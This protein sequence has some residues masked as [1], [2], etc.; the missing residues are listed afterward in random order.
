MKHLRF[1]TASL[2]VLSACS[3]RMIIQPET[4]G[5]MGSVSIALTADTSN[6][7]KV[8]KAD[9]ELPNVDDFRVAI[10]KTATKMRLY[11]D[12]YANT[13]DKTIPLNAG[14][15][16]LV[17]K[18]GDSLGCGFNKPFYMADPVFS[19]TGPGTQVKAEAKL[20]NV[21][22]AVEYDVNTINT[23]VFSDFYT[24]VKHKTYAAKK[25]KF[26][27]TETRPGYIPGGQLYLEF[28]A[29]VG[30]EWKYFETAP[31]TYSP[32]DFVTFTLTTDNSE[33]NLRVNITVDSSVE[34]KEQNIMVPPYTVA[35]E[36]PS[37][38]ISGFD[39]SGDNHYF[40]EG[41]QPGNGMASFIARGSIVNCWLSIDSDYL[42]SLG[43]PSRVDFANL[44]ETEKSVLESAGFLWDAEMNLSRKLSYIDFSGVIAKIMNGT[45]AAATDVEQARFSLSVVD[46]VGKADAAEFGVVSST[47]RASV[48][49]EDYNIWA[50]K[51]VAPVYSM[52]KGNASLLKLQVSTDNVIW[53]DAEG[54][55]EQAGYVFTHS[56]LAT[57]PSTTYYLR[58]I[59]NGNEACASPVLTVRTEDVAQ[60]GNSGFEDYQ[61]TELT[62]KPLGSSYK[63]KWYLPYAAGEI[64]PWWACN[65]RKSM[66]DGHTTLTSTWCKN[67]PSSG[68]V[69]D[70]HG[71]SKA[72]MMYCVNVG[73][74]NT[75]A[76]A[77]GTTYN[78]ELWIGTADDGGNQVNKGHS[79]LSRP[80]KLTFWY[81]YTSNGGKSF[82][83]E[84]WIKDAAGNVIASSEVTDGPAASNWTKYELPF[85]YSTLEAKA[86]SIYVWIAS[87]YE[88]GSVDSGVSFML[89]EESVKAHAGCFLTIDD[90]EL[91]Y[92]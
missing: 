84:T 4:P 83:I 20:A 71:G 41:T 13:K 6:E 81:K 72:A 39:G 90:M 31:A 2:L 7:I 36:A 73:S 78:G 70:C 77:V 89:G 51:I 10:Y 79:F 32:N 43:V 25:I 85:T 18:H 22:V 33:G 80:S 1:L 59:Y 88:D 54:T 19:V 29:K 62:V 46:A 23:T 68:Y 49:V 92:E 66:P 3:E 44:S 42:A 26:S 12:S 47:V 8:T 21:K 86:A 58:A 53:N 75:D 45:R 48:S 60:L 38:T 16:R 52:D 65:S 74:T 14:E 30:D 17:A 91:I 76:T 15:Y 27:K 69:T 67:F 9:A 55:F 40:I 35:Q 87:A 28:W 63:R 50:K 82:F 11:N 64:D 5:E 37:I 24:L 61:Q 56:N 34:D 57:E